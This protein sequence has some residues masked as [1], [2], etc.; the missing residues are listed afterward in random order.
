MRK[1]IAIDYLQYSIAQLPWFDSD[2]IIRMLERNGGLLN[3][4]A[5]LLDLMKSSEVRIG[6]DRSNCSVCFQCGTNDSDCTTVNQWQVQS[7]A[8]KC[9]GIFIQ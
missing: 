4:S 8:S 5:I 3:K 6:G 9:E 7:S 2:H 1:S